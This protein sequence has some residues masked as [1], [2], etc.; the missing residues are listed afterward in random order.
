[1]F[2]DLE[3]LRTSEPLRRLLAHYGQLA[4]PERSVWQDRPMAMDGGEARE[5]A[6]LH[7]LLIAMDWVELK[8][9]QITVLIP[10]AVPACYRVTG[11]GLRALR[12]LQ[13]RD[14]DAEADEELVPAAEATPVPK[15]PRWK[16]EKSQSVEPDVAT[17]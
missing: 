9:G 11:A 15:S 10:G 6:K 2:D 7:G 5:L 14:T 8:S 3:R 13:V 4:E 17:A 12:R 1:M 16:R